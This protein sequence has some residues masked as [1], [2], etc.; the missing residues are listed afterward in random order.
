MYAWVRF[1]LFEG[2]Y[3]KEKM[4]VYEDT[5]LQENRISEGK[6]PSMRYRFE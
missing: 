6:L 4:D 3:T 1:S 2:G 5:S